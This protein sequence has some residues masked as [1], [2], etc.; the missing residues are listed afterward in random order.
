MWDE[1]ESGPITKPDPLDKC[2]RAQTSIPA[3]SQ[4]KVQPLR[5]VIF[6]DGTGNAFNSQ[7]SNV[8]RLYQA[9]NRAPHCM[10]IAR[11]IPGVGTSAFTPFRILDS[12]TGLGVPSNVRTLYRFICWNW[13]PGAEIHLFGFS[14]GAFTIRTLAALIQKQGL[15]PVV[16]DQGKSISTSTMQRNAKGAWRAYRQQTAPATL[17]TTFPTVLLTRRI[18]DA[19]VWTKRTLLRQPH[20]NQVKHAIG[21][22]P[23]QVNIRFMGLFDTVEAYGVPIEDLRGVINYLIWP[24]RFRNTKCSETVVDVRHALA[25]DEERLSFSPVRITQTGLPIG[26][27]VQELWFPGVHSDI[28]GGYPDDA[29]AYAPLLW[30]AEEARQAGVQ[31]ND[32]ELEAYQTGSYIRAPI[33]DSRRGIYAAYR[34]APRRELNQVDFGGQPKLH[35]S[36]TEKIQSGMD[37]YGP[38]SL[39][40][41]MDQNAVAAISPPNSN[42]QARISAAVFSRRVTNRIM[43]WAL[44][45]LVLLPALAYF[46]GDPV[47]HWLPKSVTALAEAILPGMAH[48]WIRAVDMLPWGFVGLIALVLILTFPINTIMRDAIKDRSVAAW[49]DR[50]I[51]PPGWFEKRVLSLRRVKVRSSWGKVAAGLFSQRPRSIL[52]GGV[53]V[54]LMLLSAAAGY[55]SLRGA[56]GAYCTMPADGTEGPMQSLPDDGRFEDRGTLHANALCL[57][58]RVMAAPGQTYWIWLKSSGTFHDLGPELLTGN[59]PGVLSPL[60]GFYSDELK[61]RL[62]RPLLRADARW[63][64]PIAQI[65]PNTAEVL[66]LT[67]ARPECILATLS[68]GPAPA[69]CEQQMLARITPTASGE[70]M[71]YVNDVGFAPF[72]ARNQGE[73]KA[74]IA[75]A[76]QISPGSEAAPKSFLSASP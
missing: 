13:T 59:H 65:G 60:Q 8:W 72:Y 27:T 41:A 10:Q 69:E 67:D 51:D 76:I 54:G 62:A 37:G 31:W 4:A 56:K 23:G 44:V 73:A 3:G 32:D 2:A 22:G 9:L 28:G 57:R 20:H 38:V 43:S 17:R 70:I 52:L 24:I 30:I 21:R 6:A 75:Q 66:P 50:S 64:Q 55:V 11:Y 46:F 33:H 16:D 1:V 36:V 12:V 74:S 48:P 34:Y 29:V 45:A 26:Q 42:A 61:F 63:L 49:S 19:L 40:E 7:K 35:R 47:G 15:M 71:L 14:R 68:N 58:T 53:L 25:L 39:G 5:L 18:R